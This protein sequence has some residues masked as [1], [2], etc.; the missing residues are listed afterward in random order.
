MARPQKNNADFFSHDSDMRNSR[1]IRIVRKRFG[2]EGYAIFCMVLEVLADAENFRLYISDEIEREM[3]CDDL[4]LEV[5]KFDEI[6]ALF[7]QLWLVQQEE[8]G[9]LTNQHLIERM[10]PLL[11][12]REQMRAKYAGD[13]APKKPS[14]PRP[15]K[16]TMT[17]EQFEQFWTAYPLK[18]DKKKAKEKFLKLDTTLFEKIMQGIETHKK[19]RKWQEGYIA[20]PTTWLN[21]ERWEDQI[22]PFTSSPSNN[23]QTRRPAQQESPK[24]GAVSTTGSADLIV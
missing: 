5:E 18:E 21:W 15:K 17:Q 4:W 22:D 24:N 7:L 1:K 14:T 6:L 11:Y 19:W 3:L 20:H 8:D 10:W 2:N 13:K 16:P 12:K 23:G 9:A